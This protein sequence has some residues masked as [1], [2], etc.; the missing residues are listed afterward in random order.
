MTAPAPQRP[1][2][3]T[4]VRIK[5]ITGYAYHGVLDSE[6]QL[7]QTFTIDLGLWFSSATAATTDDL[8]DTVN[9]AEAAECA[10]SILTTYR[11]QLIETLADHISEE[12]L[13]TFPLLREVEVTIHKPHAPISVPFTD[14]SLT[15]RKRRPEE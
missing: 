3:D 13:T 14:L 15:V 2:D 7:G 4:C 9:Y 10:Q 11:Y 6:A 12:L 5:G 8:A 1:A